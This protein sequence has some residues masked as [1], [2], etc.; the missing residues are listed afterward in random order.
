MYRLCTVCALF[1]VTCFAL[2]VEPPRATSDEL[3][4]G[5]VS[6]FGDPRFRHGAKVTSVAV[7]PDGTLLAS[8]GE[9]AALRVWDLSSGKQ[10][11]AVQT[12]TTDNQMVRFTKSGSE[13][14][15]ALG[16][17]LERFDAQ[18]GKSLGRIAKHSTRISSFHFSP[19]E[20]L[21]ASNSCGFQC[22]TEIRVTET[23]TGQERL[24]HKPAPN[25]FNLVY[26]VPIFFSSDEQLVVFSGGDEII[27]AWR[28]AEGEKAYSLNVDGL[29][30]LWSW[31]LAPDGASLLASRGGDKRQTIVWDLLTGRER[32]RLDHNTHGVVRF[33]ANRKTFLLS[34]SLEATEEYDLQTG[35]L[36]RTLDDKTLEYLG[37]SAN[38]KIMASAGPVSEVNQ[39]PAQIC[40]RAFP[41]FDRSLEFPAKQL[42]EMGTFGVLPF[43][44]PD[45]QTLGLVRNGKT[46]WGCGEGNSIYYGTSWTCYIELRSLKDG[47]TLVKREYSRSHGMGDSVQMRWSFSP[48]GKRAVSWGSWPTLRVWNTVDG[49][50]CSGH[51]GHDGGIQVSLF[52]PSG[53]KVISADTADSVLA[54]DPSTGRKL[55][56]LPRTGLPTRAL[57]VSPDNRVLATLEELDG[58]LEVVSL[59][60]AT[61][62][63]QLIRIAR[64][65]RHGVQPGNATT[66]SAL[67]F[68]PGGAL[69]IG[70]I[71]NGKVAV[72]DLNADKIPKQS[73]NVTEETK[74]RELASLVPLDALTTCKTLDTLG[75]NEWANNLRFGANGNYLAY[76]VGSSEG[77]AVRLCNIGT[78]KRE[79]ESTVTAEPYDVPRV[80]I[81]D[82]ESEVAFVSR[83]GK[84][85]VLEV[86]NVAKRQKR[87][88][89]SD[90]KGP[91][92]SFAYS[93]D[94]KYLATGSAK[95]MINA[96]GRN[97]DFGDVLGS[98][99]RL[100]DRTNG[101]LI[102]A[103]PAHTGEIRSLNFSA[104]GKRLVSG[105]TDSTLIVWDL[106]LLVGGTKGNRE[107][108]FDPFPSAA[109]VLPN[110]IALTLAEA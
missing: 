82:N 64:G 40:L 105:S 31:S 7:S 28:I 66:L 72:W 3:P 46:T 53:D 85:D 24:N 27:E 89:L 95:K 93:P 39:I 78:E 87:Y 56:E 55:W 6:Q 15:A 76:V 44:S 101:N 69:R 11:W 63:K 108:S 58:W 25:L 75:N 48:D 86:W 10:R 26:D 110:P 29:M 88:Q 42:L 102:K 32:Y 90:W 22:P 61:T 34:R 109:I 62:G 36:L 38:G 14:I 41:G 13:L 83:K 9:D 21:V 54:W 37:T 59:W 17:N 50:E 107:S 71:T 81:C 91:L 84:A 43:F 60:D 77:T 18:S 12:E 19:S 16:N 20:K 2:A 96:T 92:S 4:P 47:K 33:T 65:Y 68:L 57:A 52:T 74:M 100:W 51:L 106:D 98:E 49:T 99:I 104:D 5:A 35:K 103:I 30:G 67:C 94:S 73:A 70:G 45:N 1:F 79:F 80:A 97:N 8:T 23:S